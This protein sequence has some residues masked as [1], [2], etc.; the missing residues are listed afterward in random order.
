DYGSR[1]RPGPPGQSRQRRGRAIFRR[2]RAVPDAVG[3]EG[4]LSIP[5]RAV[6]ASV[7]S[8][9]RAVSQ[10]PVPARAVYRQT[11]PAGAQ[12]SRPLRPGI[13]A[14][15]LPAGAMG[16]GTAAGAVS[17]QL[18]LVRRH[19]IDVESWLR[20]LPG[21]HSAAWPVDPLLDGLLRG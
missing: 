14:G 12:D 3:A 2:R 20:L 15:R 4:V 1:P 5:T 10:K 9:R 19:E 11:A 21:R 18:I 13:G 16:G 6:S 7:A 8:L 17:D